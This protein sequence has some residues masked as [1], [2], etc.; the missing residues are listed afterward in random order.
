[1]PVETLHWLDPK[2][3][4]RILDGTV[5]LGGHAR[6][7]LEASAPT[8][9]LYGC[10]R[11]EE[12][13]ELAAAN[14]EGFEDRFELR[15][16]NYADAGSW[17]AAGSLDSVLLDLGVSSL[18]LDRPERGFSFQNDGPLDMRFSTTQTTTAA[19]M[20]NT[21]DPRELAD[22]LWRFG[23]ERASRRIAA[24]IQRHRVKHPFTTTGQLASFVEKLMPRR[25]KQHPATRTFQALRIAVNDELASVAR[26]LETMLELLTVGG[27]LAVIT[28]HSTEDRLVKQF[29][30]REARDYDLPE[31]MDEDRPELR[32]PKHP[33]LEIV[34]RKPVEP[35]NEEVRNNPR[36]RSAKLRVFRKMA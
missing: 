15:Q 32:I 35:T 29:G 9:W 20:V 22:I 10:D 26:G 3:M 16:C 33:R 19:D 24:A 7:I 28:F 14:L 1:M 30:R 31:G 18:Q 4:Q 27:R 17:I 11:D 6:R 13:L 36:A 2:P 8:G 12:A 5:G 21:F 23:D 34:T 25:G